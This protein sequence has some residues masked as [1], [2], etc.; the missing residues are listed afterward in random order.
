MIPIVIAAIP[1]R[2]VT[3][4]GPEAGAAAI[5]Y[6]APVRTTGFEVATPFGPALVDLDRPM[7]SPRALL[8]LGHGA[9][10]GV[11]ARDLV[12][13][14]NAAVAAGIAVARVTQPYRVDGRRA[15]APAP[16]LDAALGAVVRALRR[17]SGLRSIPLVLG[18]R[19]SGARV[20]CRSAAA[21]GA[22]GVVALAFPVHPPGRPDRSRMP[23]LD[24][25]AVPVLVV[26]GVSDPYGM[27][28]PT[29]GRQVVAIKGT[30]ALTSDLPATAEAVVGF[31]LGL[32]PAVV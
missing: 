24:G 13:V 3:T 10:G 5:A 20:A 31:V 12:A 30:H 27:P 15:P 29:V 16:Q 9:S 1:A 23:E 18:G 21:C 22:S 11:D 32:A 25:V 4:G 14:R 28:P 19:S 6:S 8:T 2:I 7:G 26:Q 17:R